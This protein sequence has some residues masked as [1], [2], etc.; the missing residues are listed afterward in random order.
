MTQVTVKE[1]ALVVDTPVERLLQQ[2]REAGLSHT[3][4]EQ[5]VTDNEKQALL[6]HLKSSHGMKLGQVAASQVIQCVAYI[7]PQFPI[8]KIF[9]Q[10]RHGKE[11]SRFSQSRHRIFFNENIWIIEGCSNKRDSPVRPRISQRL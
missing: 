6:A 7:F 10:L 4:A 2:M 8:G 9:C 3:S 1:L 5:V 11:I